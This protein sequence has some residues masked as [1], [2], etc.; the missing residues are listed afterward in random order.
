[1]ANL[2]RR[3][4]IAVAAVALAA[5]T[6]AAPAKAGTVSG[7][8]CAYRISLSL[9]AGPAMVRGC[10]QTIPSG[11][12]G[13]AS[14]FVTLPPGGSAAPL[15]AFDADGARGVLGPAVVFGGRF[16]PDGTV[17]PSG[18]LFAQTVGTSV[19]QSTALATNVGPQPFWARSVLATCMATPAASMF[20]VQLDGAV[21]VT[22]TDQ[23][24][25]PTGAVSVPR[26]PP[27]GFR[28]PFVINNVGD[29]GVVVFNERV[30]NAD[31]STTLNAVHMYMQ[32]PIAVGD[33]VIGQ[34]RCGR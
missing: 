33:M 5:V 6:L 3:V 20:N 12:A 22:S 26:N 23:W 21:V 2:T 10:G 29:H 14:P 27:V 9:F 16:N 30:G 28:V 24:G 19:V 13:S 1:M 34:V 32:G 7:S 8:A 17:G 31:G 11:N 18:P 15:V 25:I 4:V